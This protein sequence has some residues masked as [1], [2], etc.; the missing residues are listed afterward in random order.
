[1]KRKH[2][3][4]L[5][6]LFCQPL[7]AQDQT[8]FTQFYLNPYLINPSFAGID[9]R[10]GLTVTYRKQWATLKDG[11]QIGNLT[12]HSPIS[13][14]VS[15]GVSATN[16]KRGLLDNSGLMLTFGYNI[17]IAAQSAFRFGISGGISS[18]S[19][20]FDRLQ[21][22]NDPALANLLESNMSV[23]GNAGISF[24]LNTFHAGLSLPVIF[25]PSYIS[26][27]AF[28]IS[29]IK[30]FESLIFHFS[31]RFYFNNDKNIFEPYFIYRMATNL[32]Q[33]YEIA[34]IL[35]LNH[36][37][38][39]GASL[40]QDYGISALGGIKLNNTLAIGASYGLKTTGENEL[41]SPTYEVTLGLLFGK[42]RK[43]EIPHYS[44]VDTEK[45]KIKKGTGKS[46]S[47]LIAEKRRKDELA[48]KQQ[49]EELARKKQEEERLKKE[50]QAL[51][52]KQR[53]EQ[54]RK[55]QEA[56]ARQEA[57]RKEEAARQQA[58]SKQQQEETQR[59][60]LTQQQEDAR[61][62]A[63]AQQQAE[64]QRQALQKQREENARKQQEETLRQQREEE[65]R[66]QREALAR[67]QR[68]EETRRQQEVLARQREEARKQEEARKLEE[69][70]KLEEKRLA[71]LLA[72]KTREQQ[73]RQQVAD[74]PAEPDP[75]YNST[76][77][78]DT[79]VVKHKP[80]FGHID[81]SMEI[82][83][84]EVTE[85]NEEDE[86]ERLTRIKLHANDPDEHHDGDNHPNAE[87]HEFVKKG[88]HKDELDVADYVITGVFAQES[89]ARAFTEGLKKLG[90]KAKYGHLTEKAV[91]YVYLTRT[92][93][94]NTAR[95]ER[96]KY[97]KM[98]IFRDAWLLTVH[99]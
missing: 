34:G 76:I 21:N 22:F 57:E 11:P 75:V 13:K 96:D 70:R 17:P 47:E 20:D 44:F 16:D 40:K 1:M 87:R 51:A 7:C 54:Q 9:G 27:D 60:V 86:L 97:R 53:E 90:F 23:L 71:E 29:E 78:E 69:E 89:N 37:V 18:N 98:K 3:L 94:I 62:Q 92:T 42:Q 66:Q 49:L 65:A 64:A 82:L 30:P 68:E 88:E 74:D 25:E 52:Q 31:N 79:I 48:R 4:W 5:V 19:V 63:L 59:Q 50:Q 61:K 26:K 67:Q 36:V 80:R 32:P 73:A 35:H 41:N 84:I 93:D 95:T 33:Q 28:T 91:W 72:A 10:A 38:W 2:F 55:E 6:L 56:L 15:L 45:E 12:L 46:A 81:S 58:I 39:V 85:H 77:R 43:K 99:P 8:N 83:K 14:R 24:H